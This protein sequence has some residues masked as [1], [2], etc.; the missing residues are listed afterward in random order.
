MHAKS[1]IT[2]FM[3]LIL[4]LSGCKPGPDS[5]SS[6]KQDTKIQVITTVFAL[7]EFTKEVGGDYVEVTLLLPPGAEAHSYEP[8]PGDI[9][10]IEQADLFLDIGKDMEPWA[11]DILGGIQNSRLTIIDSSTLVPLLGRE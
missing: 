3:A 11:E 6:Q 8:T 5:T 1:V 2:I 4:L 10:K 9:K 7:Y